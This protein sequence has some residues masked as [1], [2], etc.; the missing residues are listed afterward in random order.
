MSERDIVLAAIDAELEQL[1]TP[2]ARLAAR[3]MRIAVGELDALANRVRANELAVAELDRRT[4][5]PEREPRRLFGQMVELADGVDE[6]A[7]A[8]AVQ[9]LERGLDAD[10]V[11]DKLEEQGMVRR[12]RGRR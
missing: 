12:V 2:E 11:I 10:E 3:F 9:S 5:P 1:A 4:A 6:R 8:D 7:I